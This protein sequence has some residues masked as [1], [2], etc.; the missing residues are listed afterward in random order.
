M[1]L[2][3]LNLEGSRPLKCLF[4]LFQKISINVL[5]VYNL[6]KSYQIGIIAPNVAQN[7]DAREEMVA[8]MQAEFQHH[9]E[10]V[11][12]ENEHKI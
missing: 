8:A 4:V 11:I 12:A 2:S 1:I 5:L 6:P 7:M 9:V 3:L 10:G